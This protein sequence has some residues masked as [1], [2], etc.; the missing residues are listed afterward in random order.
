M[1]NINKIEMYNPVQRKLI[2]GVG[3]DFSE[4]E[5]VKKKYSYTLITGTSILL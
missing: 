1:N 4:K 2:W 5:L 3:P